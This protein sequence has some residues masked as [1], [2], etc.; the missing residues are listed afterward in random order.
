MY[1]LLIISV[2]VMS[3]VLLAMFLFLL[4][5]GL[6][7]RIKPTIEYIG[8]YAI[9]KQYYEGDPKDV[10]TMLEQQI[11]T[12]KKLDI[13]YAH[14]LCTYLEIPSKDDKISKTEIGF[15]L[16][17]GSKERLIEL[18]KQIPLDTFVKKERIVV[19]FPFKSKFS[20]Q[21]GIMKAYPALQQY[22][23][24]HNFEPGNITELYNGLEKRIEYMMDF[25]P[26]S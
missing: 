12:L 22:A 1:E 9:T 25:S 16:Y 5:Q 3:I 7:R 15:V 11:E 17:K 21:F 14:P 20:I 23:K 4:R 10:M 18:G 8:G 26:A 6:F 13:G 2:I 24:K 19:R